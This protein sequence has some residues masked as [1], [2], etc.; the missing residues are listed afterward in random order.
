L[1]YGQ[2]VSWIQGK[3]HVG[4]SIVPVAPATGYLWLLICGIGWSAPGGIIL[5]WALGGRTATQHWIVRSLL[6][7]LLLVLL[8]FSPA[9][10]W[11]SERFLRIGLVIFPHADSGL[12]INARDAHLERTLY[13]NTQNFSVLLWWLVAL[14]AAAWQ[15][16][17]TT[18][19][20][21]LFLGLGFGLGFMQSAVW[22]LGYG[23][24]PDYIDWW[25]IWELNAGFDLGVLYAIL[26]YWHTRHRDASTLAMKTDA[27]NLLSERIET[28]ALAFAGALLIFSAGF[29][30]FFWTGLFLTVFYFAAMLFAGSRVG[31]PNAGSAAGDRRRAISFIYSVFL[32]L[33][34]LFHGG[35]SRAGVILGLYSAD[36]VDQ[37]AWPLA[38]VLLFVPVAVVITAVAVWKMIQIIRTN[39]FP[40]QAG[41]DASRWSVYMIDLMAVIGFVGALSIWPA[42]IGVWYAFF[43]FL[44]L[45]AFNRMDKWQARVPYS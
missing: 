45:C 34:I 18:L 41:H 33:F 42:K 40:E 23:A 25:K 4:G 16:D 44:A 2:Y 15:R 36:A 22:C 43:L 13:T 35:S 27:P 38:R 31:R 5:G 19:V 12:Y 24:A 1:G 21:G 11:L 37:Y 26:F 7:L 14:I 3:F 17:R 9:I 6:L 8:F 39:S 32:L 30:Y 10:D 29:E 20:T 28:L